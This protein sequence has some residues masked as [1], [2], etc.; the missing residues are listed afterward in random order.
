MAASISRKTTP[1]TAI[2]AIAPGE[3]PSLPVLH[4]T[5][6]WLESCGLTHLAL[7]V[8]TAGNPTRAAGRLHHLKGACCSCRKYPSSCDD[9]TLVHAGMLGMQ[10]QMEHVGFSDIRFK[11]CCQKGH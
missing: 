9:N 2:P 11:N 7:A 4:R 1:A 10:A 5:C 8:C 3:T 6:D